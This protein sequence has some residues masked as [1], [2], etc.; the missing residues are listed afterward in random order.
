MIKLEF[1]IKLLPFWAIRGFENSRKRKTSRGGG[2][3]PFSRMDCLV[4]YAGTKES[5][6]SFLVLEQSCHE[7]FENTCQIRHKPGSVRKTPAEVPATYQKSM[8]APHPAR[9]TFYSASSERNSKVSVLRGLGLLREIR[10]KVSLWCFEASAMSVQSTKTVKCNHQLPPHAYTLT[11]RTATKVDSPV[12]FHMTR[13]HGARIHRQESFK[14]PGASYPPPGPSETSQTYFRH[15][16][17]D[18][19]WERLLLIVQIPFNTHTY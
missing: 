6:I 8:R 17:L 13:H 11:P 2:S 14:P 10:R 15:F 16:L 18:T 19:T 1:Y 9:F 5:I 4:A 7:T 12:F 3:G